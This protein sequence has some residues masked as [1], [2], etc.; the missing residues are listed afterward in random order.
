M[1]GREGEEDK[2]EEGVGKGAREWISEE[3]EEREEGKRG[4]QNYKGQ[5]RLEGS[6]EMVKN[7]GKY[8]NVKQVYKY[9]FYLPFFFFF[10]IDAYL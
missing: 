6:K 8:A 2:L 5:E 7:D 1:R 10:C 9:V 3:L 4:E